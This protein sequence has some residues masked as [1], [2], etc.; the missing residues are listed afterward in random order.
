MIKKSSG[1]LF[2]LLISIVLS[3]CDGFNKLSKSKDYEKKYEAA[4]NYYEKKD[5]FK[6]QQL[7]DEL[8][9]IFRGQPRAEVVFFKYAYSYYHMGDY[10]TAAF[11][12]QKYAVTFPKSDKTEEA[13]FMS[14]YCKY[15]DSPK[16][17][18]DQS[19]TYDAISQLQ[20]FI[21]IYSNSQRVD[22][23]NMYIDELRLK[24]EKKSFEKAKLYHTTG[25]D[26]SA[27]TALNL[28]VKN[29]PGSQHRDEALFLLL[30]ASFRYASNSVV[31]RKPERLQDS[32]QAYQA[33]ITAFPHG[34]F[35][36]RADAI[37]KRIESE[38]AK[39]NI[40]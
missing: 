20:T 26:R 34:A 33:Y 12:F 32:R 35:R 16:Y 2:I 25:Y 5:Y 31:A 27:I 17:S 23:A 29:N 38:I 39:I 15:L 1:F 30:D 18:L 21:N 8:L 4:L 6:A 40:E 22:T 19:S 37:A 28:F 14:A 3:S 36:S 11:Y 13:F 9:V 24:L 7:F 10:L